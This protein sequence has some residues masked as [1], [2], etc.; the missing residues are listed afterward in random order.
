MAQQLEFPSGVVDE[1]TDGTANGTANGAVDGVVNGTISE[2]T[3]I[4][5]SRRAMSWVY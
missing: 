3:D 1:K 5:R 4:S 2:Y